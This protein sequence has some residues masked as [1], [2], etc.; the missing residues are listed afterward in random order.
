MPEEKWVAETVAELS[1]ILN[2]Y[3]GEALLVFPFLK[4]V[5][6]GGNTAYISPGED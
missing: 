6:T 4:V 3:P 2:A 1:S 5:G